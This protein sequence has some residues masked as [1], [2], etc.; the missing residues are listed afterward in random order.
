M[1]KQSVCGGGQRRT[2]GCACGFI[3]K[4]APREANMRMRMHQK[5]CELSADI[6]ID[7]TFN[8]LQ[9]GRDGIIYSRNGNLV[10][11]QLQ[12]IMST[13]EDQTVISSIEE[14]IALQALRNLD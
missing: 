9:N 2:L 7:E 13:R 10:Q 12:V 14:F 1:S 8:P 3:T 11:R 6:R 4:G 5:K